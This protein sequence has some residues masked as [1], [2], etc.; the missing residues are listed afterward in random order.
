M[1]DYK[2]TLKA[3]G[4][5]MVAPAGLARPFFVAF[6][7][8]TASAS[9]TGEDRRQAV[10]DLQ[11]NALPVLGKIDSI[12]VEWK[13]AV[14]KTHEVTVDGGMIDSHLAAIAD[15]CKMNEAY[16][17]QVAPLNQQ[18]N[19]GRNESVSGGEKPTRE[20]GYASGIASALEALLA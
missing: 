8:S 1:S 5:A 11:A 17:L 20:T 12:L 19:V 3:N 2:V 15:G 10:V 6:N 9:V 16:R 4:K 13:D 7:P 14:G 18:Y